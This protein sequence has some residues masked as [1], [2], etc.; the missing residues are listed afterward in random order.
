LAIKE[1]SISLK[2]A[3]SGPFFETNSS[4]SFSGFP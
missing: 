2:I 4:Y 1:D 3:Y